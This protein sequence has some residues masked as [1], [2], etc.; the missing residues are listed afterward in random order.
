[1]EVAGEAADCGRVESHTDLTAVIVF[2]SKPNH[3]LLL[4]L[5][6]VTCSLWGLVWLTMAVAQTESRVMLTVEPYG[7]VLRQRLG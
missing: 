3:T 5:T 4:L 1:M 7:Q 2:G 6:L